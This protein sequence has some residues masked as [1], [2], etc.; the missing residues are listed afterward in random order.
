[1]NES[2]RLL[3]YICN[4]VRSYRH[5]EWQSIEHAQFQI[6][7]LVRP[8]LETTRNIF[9]NIILQQAKPSKPQIKLCSKAI[10]Q[11]STICTKRKRVPQLCSDF[12]ILPDDLQ[13]LSDRCTICKS[14]EKRHINVDY[15]LDYK[16]LG[17]DYRQVVNELDRNLDQ[18]TKA[19]FEFGYFFVYTT[20][21]SEP[22]DPILSYLNQ[23]I[24]EENQI[25]QEKG[26]NCL[27]SILHKKFIQFKKEY[28]QRQGVEMSKKKSV[29]LS[30]IYEL[31]QSVSENDLIEE[32]IGVIKQY[33]QKYMIE[34][35]K[36]LS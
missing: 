27:N 23:I 13:I 18:L 30:S 32:Q 36:Q 8:L 11:P 16:P 4:E 9:R 31:I 14:N 17:K 26:A 33:Q 2:N 28:E 3:H 6:T 7:Q 24:Q 29:E 20:P 25:C 34:L 1:V 19:I 35:E 15:K 5:I 22:I 10:S 12:W 21:A